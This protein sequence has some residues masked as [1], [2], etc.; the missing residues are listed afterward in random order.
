[1]TFFDYLKNIFFFL[2][3]LQIAPSILE[4]VKKQ[5]GKY[6]SPKTDVGVMSIT[7]TLHDSG[8]TIKQL[9]KIF[10]NKDIKAILLK[11]D[12]PGTVS[13]TGEAIYREI[14]TYKKLYKKPII[15]LVENVA[16]SGAYLI[17]SSC[18]HIVA[19][20]MSV[21]GSIGV[22][23]SYLFQLKEFI[24]H[25]KINYVSIKAGEYKTVGDPFINMTQKER[26]LLQEILNDSYHQ[27]IKLIADQ[28]PLSADDYKLWAEG[29]VFTGEHA[30]KLGLID[31]VGALSQAI[32]VLKEKALIETDIRWVRPAPR[33]GLWGMLNGQDQNDTYLTQACDAITQYASKWHGVIKT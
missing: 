5:Y 13:G 9:K 3:I 4:N 16:A 7:G 12:S 10:K 18:D 11:I 30:K 14:L 24:E 17:A 23:Y 32:T 1:M 6:L 28:R 33:G 25:Y 31:T 8:A 22:T 26:A 2:I 29:K 21:I 20:G 27:F 19:P 15:A